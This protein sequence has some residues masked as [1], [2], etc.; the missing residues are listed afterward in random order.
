[1]RFSD[2]RKHKDLVCRSGF[3]RARRSRQRCSGLRVT[4]CSSR[5]GVR[6][7]SRLLMSAG[8][9]PSG[10]RLRTLVV[11]SSRPERPI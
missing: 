7:S 8:Y 4:S 11:A 1:V 3:V 10:L 2:H 6:K 9:L 5:D